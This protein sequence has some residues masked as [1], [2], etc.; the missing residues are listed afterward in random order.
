MII[1]HIAPRF[2]HHDYDDE[3]IGEDDDKLA[4]TTTTMMMM[5]MTISGRA[6]I[7]RVLVSP[8]DPRHAPPVW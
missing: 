2:P 8:P 7:R 5:T 6:E 1:I 4:M 3:S